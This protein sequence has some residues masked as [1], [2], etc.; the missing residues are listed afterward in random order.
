MSADVGLC[1]IAHGRTVPAGRISSSVIGLGRAKVFMRKM[2]D[3]HW[4]R[5]YGTVDGDVATSGGIVLVDTKTLGRTQGH[6]I[7]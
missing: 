2:L 7:S 6:G 4:Q 5:L 1:M 3:T